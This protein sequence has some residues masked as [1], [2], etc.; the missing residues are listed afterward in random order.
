MK[1]LL[2]AAAVLLMT[3]TMTSCSAVQVNERMFVHLMGIS[4]DNGL[5]ELTVQVFSSTDDTAPEY[6]ALSGSGRSVSE[7]AD[8]IMRSS[9]RQ[10]FFGHCSAVFANESIIRDSD[11]LK[12]LAG[13]RISAG[14]PVFFSDLPREAVSSV[15]AEELT[16][17]VSHYREEGLAER[18]DL[19][20]VTAA[21]QSDSAAVI[22]M[23]E[24][25]LSGSAIVMPHSTS[26]LNIS[27]TA[28]LELMRGARGIRLSVLGGSVTLGEAESS[29]YYQNAESG[30]KYVIDMSLKCRIDETGNA[31]SADEYARETERII[32]LSSE[33][34][35]R[36]GL[37]EGFLPIIT[38]ILHS[39]DDTDIS[40]S[41]NVTAEVS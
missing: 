28:A 26:R 30:G 25:K 1:K 8:M 3:V 2:R 20:N 13:E 22:P 41:V 6:E 16:G 27:E 19:K 35:C 36:R 33:E 29:V 4:E 31:L 5:Y 9:G 32:A 15:S 10:L 37:S 17:I 12:M 34:I 23:W 21:I 11:K 39:P 18:A 40:F 7:A 38:P 24:E 14:C